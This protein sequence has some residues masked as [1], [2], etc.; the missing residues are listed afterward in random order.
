M[1]QKDDAVNILTEKI[2]EIDTQLKEIDLERQQLDKRLDFLLNDDPI[3]VDE[4]LRSECRKQYL[5]KKSKEQGL[6]RK[7][8]QL[9]LLQKQL[10]NTQ[11]FDSG[12]TSF[13]NV[14]KAFNYSQKND[15]ASLKSAYQNTFQKII[16]QPLSE[17]KL[18][19]N[20]VFKE[21][22]LNSRTFEDFYCISTCMATP[23]GLEPVSSP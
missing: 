13:K 3:K 4:S 6:M 14:I 9:Q 11:V 18:H 20:F 5:S 16:V 2:N 1:D 17:S 23:T 7:R 8:E 19:L 21:D 12:K 22:T 10:L 15:L